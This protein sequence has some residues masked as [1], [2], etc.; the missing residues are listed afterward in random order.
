MSDA[1]IG[2]GNAAL[3]DAAEILALVEADEQAAVRARKSLRDGALPRLPPEPEIAALLDPGESVVEV[4]SAVI[5]ER[6]VHDQPVET[7]SGRL[8]LT[9]RRLVLVGRRTMSVPLAEIE[10]LS[11]AAE[12]LLVTLRDGTGLSYDAGSPR[13]LRVLV[14][15]AVEAARSYRSPK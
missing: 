12:R 15:A 14:A 3:R 11:L 7:A 1:L 6:H 4:R 2:V 8:Y 10:E 5:V 13:L 9:T